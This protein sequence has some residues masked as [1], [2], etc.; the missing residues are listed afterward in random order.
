MPDHLP[1]GSVLHTC[2]PDVWLVH[3][4]NICLVWLCP[5]FASFKFHLFITAAVRSAMPSLAHAKNNLMDV[6]PCRIMRRCNP[7]AHDCT[8]AAQSCTAESQ[9]G[10]GNNMTYAR[11]MLL[12]MY[13]PCCATPH[14]PL[15]LQLRPST[16]LTRVSAASVLG[17]ISRHWL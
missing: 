5:S 11:C 1:A 12:L 4:H 15:S 3:S 7:A 14:I 2:T 6:H 10:C 9:T 17:E 13:R 16:R 8:A